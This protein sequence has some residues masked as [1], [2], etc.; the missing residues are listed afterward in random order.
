MRHAIS[1]G[2][3][4]STV[5]PHYLINGMILEKKVTEHKIHVLI[6]STVFV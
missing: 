6:F 3:Y 2:L 4:V 5:F 1:C